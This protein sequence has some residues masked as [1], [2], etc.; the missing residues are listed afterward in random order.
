M[1]KGRGRI[2][3]NR[4]LL[5]AN[6]FEE[7]IQERMP[8]SH[9]MIRRGYDRIGD[10]VHRYYGLFRIKW[11]SDLTYLLMKPLELFFLACLYAFDRKPENRIA[12]QYLDRADRL[13]IKEAIAQVR[14]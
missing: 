5:I 1:G 12:V 8:N 6:A 9:R 11:V 2:I 4:Q 7:L 10:M 14:T 13:R 3:C